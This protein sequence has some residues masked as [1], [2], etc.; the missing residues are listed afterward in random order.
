MDCGMPGF[1][2]LH[3][4]PQFA[5]TH[6]RWIG[7]AIQPTCPLSPPSPPALNLSQYQGLFQRISSLHQGAKYCSFSFSISPSSEYSQLIS[8]RI[9]WFDLLAI[10]GTLKGLFQHH[11]SKV[12]ILQCSAFLMVQL[13]HPYMTTGKIIALIYGPLSAKWC[14]CFLIRCR[15]LS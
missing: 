15:G 10:Q 6:I 9:V 5:Q 12:S 1:P 4:L 8:F 2:V 13:L 7:D 14:L 11:S 3:Y